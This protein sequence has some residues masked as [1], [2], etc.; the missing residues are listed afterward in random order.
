MT[1][2][3]DEGFGPVGIID[4]GSNSVRFVAYGG[5]ARVPAVLFNEK[6]MAGLGQGLDA[7]GMLAAPAMD[8]AL[9]ALA[10]FGKLASYLKLARIHTVATAA[11]RD[12]HNGAAFM[13]RV[14]ELGFEPMLLGGAEEAQLAGMGVLSAIPDADGIAADLGGGSLELVRVERGETGEGISLPL[15]VLRIDPSRLDA[16]GLAA[17]IAGAVAG[18]AL[19]RAASGR[20]LYLVGG[21]WRSL[22][23]IDLHVAGSALPIVHQHRMSAVRVREL[24]HILG[25]TDRQ[26]L[27]AIP[28]LSGSRIPTL[29]AAV[30]LLDA[31][32]ST[33]R[34]SD[35]VVSAY[36]L[37]EG[38]LFRELDAAQ[39]SVDPL[40][41]AARAV[42]GRYGRFGDGGD[43]LDAWIAPTF[44]GDG[45]AHRRLRLAAC[46][47]ADIAWGAHP[48]FRAE[49]AV[50][51][52]IH[53]NW[54]GIDATGRAM[55]GLALFTSFGGTNGFD[56]R[57]AA[58]ATPAERTRAQQW[59]LAIRLGRRL[60]GGIAA[61][62]RE[63]RLARADGVLTLSLPGVAAA[64]AGEAV[65]R[66]HRQLASA[67]GLEPVLV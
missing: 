35:M 27:R 50:D 43:L 45:P 42:G 17:T 8:R 51:M 60:G 58:L 24:G 11:V 22:G 5:N 53:G 49:R 52:A 67:L 55:L 64:L 6:V 14:A 7:S 63:S 20:A 33:L 16:A 9:S 26:A 39:R 36:G 62:L 46:L 30:A 56:P 31:L 19:A 12:A 29:P 37:R 66:R 23:L 40:L 28:A 13:T 44:A 3:A 47:L 32:A 34:P 65:G 1:T 18:T 54:V 21:S 2:A 48:D 25:T 38:L 59:G 41:A 15:G 57:I 61:P 4:I 10:R